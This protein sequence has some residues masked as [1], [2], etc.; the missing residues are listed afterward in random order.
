MQVKI[1]TSTELKANS[2]QCRPLFEPTLN[3]EL[4]FASAT[5]AVP[6]FSKRVN[7]D[8]SRSLVGSHVNAVM[9]DAR[10]N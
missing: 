4:S 7:G 3:P 9:V 8:H 6:H 2:F 1:F 5:A 10:L